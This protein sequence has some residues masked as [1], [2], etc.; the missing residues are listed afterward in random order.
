MKPFSK[1]L[2]VICVLGLLLGLG[3]VG[4]PMFSGLARAVGAV[5]FILFFVTRMI[6]VL[7]EEH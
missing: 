4:N 7:S 5:F 1:L 6:D 2:L 3:D